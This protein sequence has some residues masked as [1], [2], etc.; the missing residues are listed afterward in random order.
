MRSKAWCAAWGAGSC[1]C[2][3]TLRF[4]GRAGEEYLRLQR[5]ILRLS[6]LL[7]RSGY[8]KISGQIRNRSFQSKLPGHYCGSEATASIDKKTFSLSRTRAAMW[9]FGKTGGKMTETSKKQ[10][11]PMVRFRPVNRAAGSA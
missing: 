5:Q 6:F 1:G 9:T 4:P 10:R 3:R 11:E 2:T 8:M 7:P